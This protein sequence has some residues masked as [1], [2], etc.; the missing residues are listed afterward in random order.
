METSHLLGLMVPSITALFSLGFLAFWL[1]GRADTSLLTVSGAFGLITFGFIVTQYIINKASFWNVPIT[2]LFFVIGISLMVAAACLR[3]NQSVPIRTL[4]AIGIIGIG[5]T[6]AIDAA[7]LGINLRILMNNC[8]LGA[9][10]LAGALQLAK[11]PKATGLN[12]VLFWIMALIGVQLI[13]VSTV[14]LAG[15][16]DL[17]A[18]SYY[19]SGYWLILNILTLLSLFTLASAFMAGAAL[20]YAAN[21][22]HEAETD[23][24]TGLRTRR[25]FER[26]VE[27]LLAKAV[28]PSG[29]LL[30]DLDHFKAVNDLHGHTAGDQTLKAIGGLITTM[31]R[32][33]DISGRVGGEE[34]IIVLKDTALPATRMFAESLRQAIMSLEI[35]ALPR[36]YQITASFGIN[37]HMPGDIF[38]KTY[39]AADKALYKSKETGRNKVSLA[40]TG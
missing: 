36:T 35:G 32:D 39:K 37:M 6:M 19:S 1:K 26:D 31:I 4:S 29:V 23:L 24:L 11:R 22:R 2:N 25:A 30:F 3:R 33:N 8:T 10:F 7:S 27:A 16:S 12:R 40:Q 17:T 34:F 38:T 20:D 5:L 13:A 28:T 21:I 9:L 14:M 18:A 15:Q